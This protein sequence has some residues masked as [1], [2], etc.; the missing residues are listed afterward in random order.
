MLGH[1]SLG[2]V[3][4]AARTEAVTPADSP[5]PRPPESTCLPV[6][7]RHLPFKGQYFITDDS[8]VEPDIQM[9]SNGT[10]LKHLNLELTVDAVV[11]FPGCP[12]V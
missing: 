5:Q 3:W 2:A 4:V 8:F 11:S 7:Q 10:A 9:E 1:L 12:H 6:A